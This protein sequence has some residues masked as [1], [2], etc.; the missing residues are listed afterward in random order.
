M[1]TEIRNLIITMAPPFSY[2]MEIFSV[3][4]LAFLRNPY[5]FNKIYQKVLR[6]R[7]RKKVR[8]VQRAT[9]IIETY[10][11]TIYPKGRAE[12]L[13]LAMLN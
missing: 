6:C 12:E 7:I 5:K 13:P 10:Y 8:A 3:Q 1:V 2:A 11:E 9:W 4:E